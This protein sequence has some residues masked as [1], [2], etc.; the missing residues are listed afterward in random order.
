MGS[1][2]GKQEI[3]NFVAFCVGQRAVVLGV[4]AIVMLK[5]WALITGTNTATMARGTV[6]YV[7]Y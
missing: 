5:G 3:S 4:G 2:Y 6:T 1:Y 7:T